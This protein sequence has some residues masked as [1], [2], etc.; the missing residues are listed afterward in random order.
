MPHAFSD[1]GRLL[2]RELQHDIQLFLVIDNAKGA[3]AFGLYL[4]P[5]VW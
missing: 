3:L 4:L 2:G 5:D 1:I